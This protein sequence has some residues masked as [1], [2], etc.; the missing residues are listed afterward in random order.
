MEIRPYQ[1]AETNSVKKLWKICFGDED[2]YIDWCF[3]KRFL[4]GEVLTL[5]QEGKLCGMTAQ[6][7]YDVRLEHTKVSCG[8]IE[9]LCTHPDFRHRHV[10][11][12]LMK[13]SL[14]LM[15]ES[16]R[17][18]CFLVPFQEEFYRRMGFA[19]YNKLSH[20]KRISADFGKSSFSKSYAVKE[21]RNTKDLHNFYE[22]ITS[23]YDGN[24]VRTDRVWRCLFEAALLANGRFL[25]A[26]DGAELVGYL[27]AEP[28]KNSLFVA[29][30]LCRD[31]EV[32][33][34]L[35]T[36]VTQNF[37]KETPVNLRVDTRHLWGQG[38]EF[39]VYAMGRIVDA[40][41]VLSLYR[42]YFSRPVSLQITDD[43]CPWNN[44]IFLVDSSGVKR[45][46]KGVAYDVSLTSLELLDVLWGRIK[47]Q[48]SLLNLPYDA[49]PKTFYANLLFD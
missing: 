20:G 37:S 8:F 21:L 36:Y 49:L 31:V 42:T 33:E 5:W 29:E 25:G 3:D 43:L 12:N 34:S 32:Q 30:M 44:G 38:E 23:L 39:S 18:F 9:G 13:Q 4:P 40:E 24:F 48:D 1:K 7:S 11:T 27:Y 41:A 14:K 45:Q 2:S 10:A 22:T 35:F 6:L 26:F 15:K 19:V 47:R 28:F 17:S 46:N 16:G